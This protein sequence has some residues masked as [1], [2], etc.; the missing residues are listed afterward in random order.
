MQKS[1]ICVNINNNS[2]LK[3]NEAGLLELVNNLPGMA[4]RTKDAELW[5]VNFISD[6]CLALT[7]YTP[8][9]IINNESNSYV[10]IINHED[11][12]KAW[13]HAQSCLELKKAFQVEYRI[14]TYSGKT[15]WV[16]EKGVGCYSDNNEL[17]AIESFVIDITNRVKAEEK[18]KKAE[19]SAL[20]AWNETEKAN[21]YLERAIKK[22]EEANQA[23][24]TFLANMSHEIRTPMNA[25]IGFSEILLD[26]EGLGEKQK[27]FV[28]IIEESAKNLLGIINDILDFSK[29]ESGKM[30]VEDVDCSPELMVENLTSIFKFTTERKGLELY[31]N[32]DKNLPELIRTDPTKLRQCLIN[33]VS[34]SL[35]FTSRGFIKISVCVEGRGEKIRFDVQDTG[36]GIPPK[37]QKDIFSAFTQVDEKTSRRFGGSGLGLTI[38]RNL[39][40]LLGGELILE[41]ES[42]KGSTFSIIL[43][44]KKVEQADAQFTET[45]ESKSQKSDTRSSNKYLGNVLVAEDNPANQMLIKVLLERLG[46]KPKIVSDGA[47]AIEAIRNEEI[48]IVF[49]DMQM[50]NINGYEATRKLREMSMNM[51]IIAL[52]ASALVEDK[53]SCIEAGCNEYL[54]KPIK[55]E[56]LIKILDEFL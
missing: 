20:E 35:K 4:Y 43:P 14:T 2:L 5:N 38:T 56:E 53:Q 29:I 34:N 31:V 16:L 25:I 15:K 32:F 39:V 37:K 12:E 8:D 19:K 41:S 17:I 52:T 11:C 26:D 18:L 36:I 9:E 3:M 51:P 33:L 50:P 45:C 54:T 27:H 42:G 10:S 13:N 55:H 1:K 21:K 23:K 47:E 40:E 44:L 24:S 49:M 48:D 46:I 6:G 30:T 28:Q 7:G 22:T